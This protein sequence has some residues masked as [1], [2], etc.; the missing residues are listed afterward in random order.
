MSQ[1]SPTLELGNPSLTLYA[2]HL[3]NS[4]SHG[5]QNPVPKASQ[6]WEQLTNLGQTLNIPQLQTLTSQLICYENDQYHPE[7]EDRQGTEYFNLLKNQAESLDFQLLSQPELEIT[8]FLSPFRYHDTYFIDLTL[9]SKNN[10]NSTHLRNFNPQYQLLPPHLQ[11]SLGQTLFFYAELTT[12]PDNY[13]NLADTCVQHLLPQTTSVELVDEGRLLDCPI[14]VYDNGETDPH[15]QLHL[16]IWFNPNSNVLEQID[17]D[18]EKQLYEFLHYLLWSRHKILY[19]YHQSRWCYDKAKPH[20]TKIEQ[21]I[22]K[23]SD[24]VQSDQRLQ[25]FKDLLRKLPTISLEYSQLLRE[26]E[27]HQTT[28]QTNIQNYNNLIAKLEQL[29][30]CDLS[31]L[32]QFLDRTK[33]KFKPQ[34]EADLSFLSPAQPLFQE[35][36]NNIR[37]IVAIDQIENDRNFQS[38]LQNSQQQFEKNLQLQIQQQDQQF[39]KNLQLQDQQFQERLREQDGKSE[40]RAKTIEG[41]IAFFGTGLAVSGVSAGVISNPGET[42]FKTLS[43]NPPSFCKSNELVQF[44]CPNSFDV[45]FHLIVGIIFA[46]PAAIFI[47]LV[48]K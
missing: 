7:A 28:I 37:S 39:Q 21:E 23:F 38:A 47:R 16:I 45:V 12:S 30:N 4:I 43:I 3:R 22:K 41:W 19:A 8:G 34:I 27:D 25:E 10:I 1:N 13:S 33:N 17:E 29:P 14:F 6:I 11:T 9:S 24:R 5:F 18:T 48:A 2:F 35:L 42:I 26:I 40:E 32:Q 20:Y 44:L 31:F 46:I 15:Q 36:L